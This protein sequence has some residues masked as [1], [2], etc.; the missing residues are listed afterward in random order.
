MQF[1][2]PESP[3]VYTL[4]MGNFLGV[5]FTSVLPNI[6]RASDML[7]MVNKNGEFVTRPGQVKVGNTFEVLTHTAYAAGTT[8]DAT[9]TV[10]YD[11]SD[12]TCILESTGNLPTNE[13]Y[14]EVLNA[15]S[16]MTQLQINGVWNM[17]TTTNVFL[18]HA[19]TNLYL[20][21]AAFTSFTLL[22]SG[23]TD[24]ISQ[25][26]LLQDKLYIFDGTRAIVYGDFSGWQAK[27]LDEIGYVPT[28]VISAA[29][30]GTGAQAYEDVNLTQPLRI[31]S[32]LSNGADNVYYLSEQ[33]I[34]NDVTPTVT[35]LTS[36]GI[37][38]L[39]I[40]EYSPTLGTVTFA[41]PPPVSPVDGRDNIF[42]RYS[43]TSTENISYINKCTIITS[44][45]YDGNN[46]RLFVTGN[47]DFP[48]VDWF[49]ASEDGTYFPAENY[50]RVGFEP[51]INYIK[52]NDG[53]LGIQKS[54]TDT[55]A[56]MYYRKSA[57]Y[58]GEEVF[59]IGEGVK[60]IGCISKHANANLLNDPLTLTD[61][62]VY[63]V[64]GSSYNEKFAMERS[65]FVKKRLLAE[66]NLEN[67]IAITYQNKYYLA[68]NDHVYV[69]D[70]D[71][72]SK[73]EGNASNF[74]YEWY[75]WDNCPV[76]IWFT[77][78]GDLYFGTD[79]GQIVKFSEAAVTDLT[80]AFDQ[81]YDTAYLDFNSI[82]QS[83]T[84]KRVT[85]VSKPE[86]ATNITLS[87]VTVDEETEIVDKTYTTQTF[88]MVLQEK[89]KIKKFMFVKFRLSSDVAKKMS[90]YQIA[91]EYIYSG[92]YRGD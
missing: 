65:S 91:I 63:G 53:K 54:L 86:A 30:D 13:T 39:A 49:S 24:A 12:Y 21:N 89:E 34:D 41:S 38:S 48:N 76:R 55:D 42:I 9:D 57:L 50:T 60:T 72:K 37:E 33:D 36:G 2:V 28:L 68:I 92:H 10:S 17:D 84:V 14:W 52:T 43:K 8:Y 73:I 7:N 16:D 19:G 67:A 20:S 1:K 82:T 70:S 75:Y 26:L 80:V 87:Y 5:D 3:K 51:I 58:A 81:Y 66:T 85:V 59:P 61:M 31:N 56:T 71:Y 27:Y 18:V 11:G 45:G 78:D 88:P 4:T 40:S 6:K 15:V 69:A 25:G 23:L 44:Y 29:P 83:K 47:P 62:G 77:F 79:D 64:I 90:F 74:Q 32:F 22:K 35:I 46:N